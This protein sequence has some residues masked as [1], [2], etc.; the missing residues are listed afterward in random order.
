MAALR[1]KWVEVKIP[2]LNLQQDLGFENHLDYII[3][4]VVLRILP[5]AVVF[6]ICHENIPYVGTGVLGSGWT[7]QQQ[8]VS[9]SFARLHLSPGSSITIK[10]QPHPSV[11]VHS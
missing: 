4:N 6:L 11:R 1:A 5:R 9:G 8:D 2:P 7:V 3:A 10:G